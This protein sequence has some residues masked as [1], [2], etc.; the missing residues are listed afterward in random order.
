MPTW[1]LFV[2][3]LLAAPFGAAGGVFVLIGVALAT[4][5]IVAA[6]VDWFLARDIHRILVQRELATDK[7]SLGG[8][9]PVSLRVE[10]ATPVRN[11][12]SIRDV[13]PPAFSLDLPVPL[14]SVYPGSG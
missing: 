5:A 9:N 12:C 8:W 2:L 1:R 3:L 4:L 7:L 14:F 13:P 10:N 11:D 6:C